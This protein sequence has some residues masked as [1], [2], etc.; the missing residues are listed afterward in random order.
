MKVFNNITINKKIATNLNLEKRIQNDTYTQY[1]PFMV[2]DPI[3]GKTFPEEDRVFYRSVDAQI[4]HLFFKY[5]NKWIKSH[6][7]LVWSTDECLSNIVFVLDKYDNVTDI[8]VTCRSTNIEQIV[9]DA[10][11]VNYL[12]EKF[13]RPT[14]T[15]SITFAQLHA[16]F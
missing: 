15:V 1:E 7:Q 2:I 9:D 13:G 5:E 6:R 14:T 8:M 16:F 10:R 12:K 11:F 3:C 4:T